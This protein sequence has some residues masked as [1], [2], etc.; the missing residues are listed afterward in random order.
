MRVLIATHTLTLAIFPFFH[1]AYPLIMKY[2][3][4]LVLISIS[5][6]TTI[7]SYHL[8]ILFCELFVQIF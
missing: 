1:F 4:T 8:D 6:I 2:Y 7:V 5:L 3:H